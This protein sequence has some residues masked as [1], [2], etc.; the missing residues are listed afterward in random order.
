MRTYWKRGA[1]AAVG[2]ALLSMAVVVTGSSVAGAS[3]QTVKQL[4]VSN[5]FGFNEGPGGSIGNVTLVP[6]PATAPSGTGSAKLQVDSTG[7]ASLGT[8]AYKGTL[9]SQITDMDYWGYVVGGTTNQLVFQFDV[10]YDVTLGSTAYQGRLTFV[11]ASPPPPN[12]WRHLNALT[13]GSWFGSQAPGNAVCSQ[14]TPCSWSQ[15]LSHFPH[16]AIRNDPIGQGALLLR[17]GGPISGGAT[18]YADALTV[19]TTSASTTTDFEPGGSIAPSI[20]PSGTS[21][22]A[23]GYGFRPNAK[24]AVKYASGVRGHRSAL[25]CSAKADATGAGQCTGTIPSVAGA[26][27]AHTVTIKGRGLSGTVVYSDDFVASN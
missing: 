20:G 11:P 22:T 8:N 4:Q 26:P 19:A 27:G 1:V 10:T 23:Y 5:W 17:L 13:D 24:M 3:T 9:L 12:A 6:G 25:I 16:A 21:I 18:A 15:V 2:A 7:R 14:A